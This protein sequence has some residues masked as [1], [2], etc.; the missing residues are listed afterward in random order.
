MLRLFLIAMMVAPSV[1]SAETEDVRG[2]KCWFAD[3]EE[4]DDFVITLPDDGFYRLRFGKGVVET[5]EI[6]TV[7]E[8]TTRELRTLQL[9]TLAD[10]KR[11]IC[12][13]RTK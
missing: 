11:M 10:G 13:V 3:R 7:Q 4:A 12:D 5:L 6:L 2:L 1:A 9:V 8:D